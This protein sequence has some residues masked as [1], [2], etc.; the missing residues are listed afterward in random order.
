M[1]A[2]QDILLHRQ[3]VLDGDDMPIWGYYNPHEDFNGFQ[4]PYVTF[5][6]LQQ[7]A[8]DR[9]W[10]ITYSKNHD[11]V[12]VDDTDFYDELPVVNRRTFRLGWI[13]LIDVSGWIWNLLVGPMTYDN[14]FSNLEDDKSI[15]D[16]GNR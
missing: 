7:F 15:F 12:I 3:F 2:N 11:T 9:G 13:Q 14:K 10:K 1:K 6:D 8:N 4:C 5:Q 16:L